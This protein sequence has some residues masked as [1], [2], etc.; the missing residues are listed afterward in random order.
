MS[1][2][3]DEST[4]AKLTRGPRFRAASHEVFWPC[5]NVSRRLRIAINQNSL[6]QRLHCLNAFPLHLSRVLDHDF[7][8]LKGKDYCWITLSTRRQK[9]HVSHFF[10]L[11]RG[12]SVQGGRPR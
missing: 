4:N 7:F 6:F 1:S 12:M 9:A 5:I 2:E 11:R 10:H 8:L 3:A